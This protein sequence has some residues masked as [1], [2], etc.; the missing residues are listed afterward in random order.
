M[1]EP[2]DELEA[3]LARWQPRPPSMLLQERIR[4]S[5]IATNRTPLRRATL[6]VAGLAA[7]L[8]ITLLLI[9]SDRVA[10]ST[11]ALSTGQIA[12]TPRDAPSVL[13]Y[14]RAYAHSAEALDSLLDRQAVQ[15]Q[16]SVQ[17]PSDITMRTLSPNR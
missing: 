2:F 3:E 6:T 8:L 9:P 10:E 5:L 15:Q 4:A 17:P 12:V 13:N 7:S 11:V 14:S 1:N 16:L